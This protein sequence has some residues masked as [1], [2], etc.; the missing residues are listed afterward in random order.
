MVGMILL[1]F[2]V[3]IESNLCEKYETIT[4]G[5]FNDHNEH[6]RAWIVPE[7]YLNDELN[8]DSIDYAE[9][10]A[11]LNIP[12]QKLYEDVDLE[13]KTG[14]VD[15]LDYPH[16]EEANLNYTENICEFIKNNCVAHWSVDGAK[17]FGIPKKQR[18]KVE[19]SLAD[20]FSAI[21]WRSST[22]I[23]SQKVERYWL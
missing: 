4:E 2:L 20:K 15:H 17:C 8:Q 21:T 3:L 14:F 19:Q 5:V 12:D 16:S 23:E 22:N 10:L 11:S 13:K 7:F 6:R 18:I 1:I 9:H